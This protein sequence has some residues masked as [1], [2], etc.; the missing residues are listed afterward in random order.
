MPT[1][2]NHL[3]F[4]EKKAQTA[5]NPNQG[6]DLFCKDDDSDEVVEGEALSFLQQ[7]SVKRFPLFVK[8]LFARGAIPAKRA[9]LYRDFFVFMRFF[10]I[11]YPL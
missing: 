1:S 8:R 3:L 2:Y 9:K 4:T 6:F 11:L 5:N 10:Q 7:F